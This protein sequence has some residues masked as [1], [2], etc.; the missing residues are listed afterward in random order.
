MG[1]LLKE[2]RSDVQRTAKL[3]IA[4]T[5]L[6]LLSL[7]FGACSTGGS[8]DGKDNL[9][10]ATV[11]GKNIML[12]EVERG[13]SQQSGGRQAQLSQLEL[14]QARLQV[15]GNLIQREVLFQRAE[16]EKALPT[17]DQITAIINQQKQQSGMTDDDFAKNLAAQNLTMES[18]REEAR[19]DIAIKNLQEKYSSKITVNDKEVEDFYNSNRDRFVSSRGVALAMI[20]A[21]PAD[22]TSQ[23]ISQ[24]DAKNDA[25]AKLK[26][27]NIYQQLKGGADFA[28]VARAKSEDATSLTRGGDLGFATEEDLKQN[29]FPPELVSRF[30]TMQAGDITEPIRFNSGK[31]YVF[32]LEE[33]RLQTENLTLESPGVRQQIT[34]ALINQRKD[35]LNAALLEVAMNDAKIVNNMASTMLS[36]PSNLGLRPASPGAVASPSASPTAAATPRASAPATNSSPSSAGSPAAGPKASASPKR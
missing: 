1:N 16:R 11:N 31:W 34:Q 35:I 27:D 5:I 18:L 3:T 24:N 25:E 10:A 33:K 20:V 2:Q 12:A 7:F 6:A 9:V 17:E 29:A 23:G 32:K 8:S 28:T 15:L 13:V 22:N 21:D 14:A 30:F 4:A 36:N 19:K 26:I